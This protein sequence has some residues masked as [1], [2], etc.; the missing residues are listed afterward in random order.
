M[1]IFK[2]PKEKIPEGIVVHVHEKGWMDENGM[3]LW[4]VPVSSMTCLKLTWWNQ[5]R[6]PWTLTL[7]LFQL[8]NLDV[9]SLFR[10]RVLWIAD[11]TMIVKVTKGGRLNLFLRQTSKI[12]K[13]S[14][15][16]SP[17]LQVCLDTP[18]V[19]F[20]TL[21]LNSFDLFA[22]ATTQH[23][24]I[25]GHMPKEISRVSFFFLQ[26]GGSITCEVTGPRKHS[27]KGLVVPCTY[28]YVGHM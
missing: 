25:V 17:R 6:Q 1:I 11:D 13:W 20:Y 4:I 7:Q 23:G 19:K 8:V 9:S 24:Q 16:T 21:N 15:L 12:S 14:G 2:M 3:K 18:P 5:S 27:G 28:E 10:I 22:V 26:H